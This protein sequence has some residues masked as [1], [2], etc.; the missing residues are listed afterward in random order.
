MLQKALERT[1]LEAAVREEKDGETMRMVAG[2]AILIIFGLSVV[3]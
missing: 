3:W 1:G 2:Q